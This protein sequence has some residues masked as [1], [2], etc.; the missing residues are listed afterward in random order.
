MRFLEAGF[1]KPYLLIYIW[2]E[3][4]NTALSANPAKLRKA[5]FGKGCCDRM[6][7]LGLPVK[8][9]TTIDYIFTHSL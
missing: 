8:D 5:Q 6:L 3:S 4:T 9:C 2:A 1:E 7:V